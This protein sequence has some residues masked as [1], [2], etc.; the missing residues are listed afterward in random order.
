MNEEWSI[1]YYELLYSK[2]P[3]NKPI[4]ITLY[5][6]PQGIDDTTFDKGNHYTT[7]IIFL[8]ELSTP[9]KID[10][11][12]IVKQQAYESGISST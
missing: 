2:I 11:Q 3:I 7:Y 5:N 9:L 12:D 4:N 8:A 6:F 10:D 1:E